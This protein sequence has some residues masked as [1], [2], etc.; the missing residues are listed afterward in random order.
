MLLCYSSTKPVLSLPQILVL[1]MVLYQYFWF[2][3]YV[4]IERAFISSFHLFFFSN[5]GCFLT[6]FYTSGQRLYFYALLILWY[7][8]VYQ[9]HLYPSVFLVSVHFP[10]LLACTW[11]W[12]WFCLVIYTLLSLAIWFWYIEGKRSR[13]KTVNNH[14]T[15][16]NEWM[17]EHRQWSKLLRA[18]KDRNF[19]RAIIIHISKRHIKEDSLY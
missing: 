10:F 19:C 14:L 5:Y 15:S 3:A 6:E 1:H 17:T 16:L 13:A 12:F 2:L 18:T 11:F 9:L 7:S 4:F 8:C